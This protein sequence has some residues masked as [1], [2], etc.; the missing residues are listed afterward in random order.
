MDASWSHNESTEPRVRRLR[1]RRIRRWKR[2]FRLLSPLL[3]IPALLAT[4]SLSVGLIE[5]SPQLKA[6]EASDQQP[7]QVAFESA[8]ISIDFQSTVSVI[9]VQLPSD[10]QLLDITSLSLEDSMQQS[11]IFP[12][13]QAIRGIR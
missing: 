13:P 11:R 3:G 1:G 9:T 10:R 12:S 7:V 5:H 4:L 8:P 2:R 6:P